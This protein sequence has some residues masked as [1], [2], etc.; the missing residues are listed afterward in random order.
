MAKPGETIRTLGIDAVLTM[1]A[2]GAKDPAARAFL[3]SLSQNAAALSRHGFDRLKA[4]IGQRG[5][6]Q[7]ASVDRR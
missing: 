6:N 2:K 3:A 5:G 1:S 4:D 7:V